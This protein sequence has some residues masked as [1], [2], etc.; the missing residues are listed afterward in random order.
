MSIQTTDGT[1]TKD[2][3]SQKTK[4]CAQNLTFRRVNQFP[5]V[6]FVV[7]VGK[8]I[9]PMEPVFNSIGRVEMIFKYEKPETEEDL[10]YLP[11]LSTVYVGDKFYMILKY[12][13]QQG[14]LKLV[15]VSTWPSSQ[16]WKSDLDRKREKKKQG[17]RRTPNL[18]MQ[19]L[20][21]RFGS[22]RQQNRWLSRLEM[23]KRNPGEAIA[24]LADDLRQMA[25]R[26]YIDL[27]ARAQEVLA[28]NQ[29]YKS[30]TPEVKYQCTN[31]GCRTVAGAVEVIE[32]Y[33]AIIGDGSE[34]KK[35]SVRMTTDTHLGEASNFSQE[36]SENQFHDS[37]DGLTRRI[38]QLEGTKQ[39]YSNSW[40]N[41]NNRRPQWGNTNN[42]QAKCFICESTSH[43]CRYCPF[44][45]RYKQENARHDNTGGQQGSKDQDNRNSQSL[46]Q[47]N[48]RTA[49]FNTEFLVCDI[50]QDAILGQDFLLDHIDKID[51]KR[52]IL[53]TKDTD[54]RCWIG[55]EANAICRVIVKETVTLPGKSKM[56]IPVIIE[57]AE[58]LGP[59][60]YVDKTQKKETEHNITRGILDPHQEDIRVQ[61]INFREEPITVHAKEQIGVCESYYEMPAVGVCNYIGTEGTSSDKLPSH[62]EDLFNRS[63]V[64][65]QEKEKQY[66]KE[67][68]QAYSDVFAKSADD[69]G[70]TNRVQHRINTGT[71]HPIRQAPRRLPLGKREIEKKEIV[72]MLDRGVIEPSNSPWSFRTVLIAKKDGKALTTPPILV[73][74][75]T[76]KTFILDT[77]ASNY[78]VGAVLSQEH[79]GREHVIAYMSKAL[80]KHE[81]SYCTTRKELLA[82]IIALKNFHPYVYGTPVLLRTDNA[83]VSWLQSLK[84]PTGQVARWLQTLGTY[85]F[86]VTHRAGR[87]HT[88]ADAMSRNPCKS[89]KHQEDLNQ[90]ENDNER[91]KSENSVECHSNLEKQEETVKHLATPL[92]EADET[93]DITEITGLIP[94]NIRAVTR[95]ELKEQQ[96][97]MKVNEA[98]LG[99]WEPSEI[100]QQQLEDD[101]IGKVFAAFESGSQKPPWESISSG[102]SALKTLWGQWDRLEIHGGVLYR[103][104]ETNIGQTARK[105][106]IVPKSRTQDLL[107]HFHDVPSAAHL[108]VDKTL[109]KLK[110]GFYW[111]NMK[112]YVQAYCRSCDSCFARKP[113]KEST[114]APLGTYV[115]GEPMERGEA[116]WIYDPIR[117]KGV[118]S[119]LTPKWKGPFI[120]E[121]R[122]DDVTYRVKR[123]LRQPSTVY[124]VDRL[125]LYQGRNVPSW[126]SRFRRMMDLEEANNDQQLDKPVG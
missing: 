39:N 43:L 78:A 30:V 5:L 24:A 8:N 51:Y 55:G 123:S 126:A 96:N 115:S 35:G 105:Q 83:A 82:V 14:K 20:G 46:N 27:D 21:L 54:I 85:N 108:G 86:K 76:D 98:L 118:C 4:H 48:F 117:K 57:N 87:K 42:R 11:D 52:Q 97:E 58:H 95:S 53:S 119:K 100:R 47:G 63:I 103:R 32:R 31:Q 15:L 49:D 50:K 60:G 71:A 125:A 93:P 16:I 45:L 77:D 25:Q 70:R 92:T 68:L 56:L 6:E 28:L 41:N 9:I 12:I 94:G 89:C 124:H 65:L 73:Y 34:K 3:I 22:T 109:E 72:K 91:E 107:H 116:V 69:L 75:V 10:K 110:N 88:N 18:R 90:A 23:R 122:I 114:K 1:I 99:G 38:S 121:K 2:A 81:I 102:T 36:P 74:P 19:R 13:G 120:I 66:L 101:N 111:P 29:L 67:L 84:D 80:N 17:M 112:E 33:E 104:F 7:I 62:I 26:A 61:L 113:K 79:D 59:L 44:Y 64:H 37:I 40:Q 106:M